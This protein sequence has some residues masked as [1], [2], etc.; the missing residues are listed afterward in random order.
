MTE[1]R[2]PPHQTGEPARARRSDE[3][4][5]RR[6]EQRTGK[7]IDELIV[8][9]GIGPIK[10]GPLELEQ[11]LIE[12]CTIKPDVMDDTE[13]PV[14]DEVLV[15]HPYRPDAYV[16]EAHV[17]PEKKIAADKEAGE[18]A[19]RDHILGGLTAGLGGL[20]A[21]RAPS[22]PRRSTPR[23]SRPG[24][25]TGVKP[26]AIGGAAAA[27]DHT[28]V[29]PQ[30]PATRSA[31]PPMKQT[32]AQPH[33]GR[34]DD[35]P[36]I[37]GK[38]ANDVTRPSNVVPIRPPAQPETPAPHGEIT[39]DMTGSTGNRWGRGQP[40]RNAGGGGHQ[41]RT[42][43]SR[44]ITSQPSVPPGRTQPEPANRLTPSRSTTRSRSPGQP[45]SRVRPTAPTTKN[46]PHSSDST[47]KWPPDA[48]R[49][50]K[51]A[52]GEP[53]AAEWRY[54]R[55]RQT[56]A[57]RGKSPQECLPFGE[58]KPLYFDTAAAGGRP[59]RRGGAEQVAAKRQLT[60]TEGVRETEDVRLG[61][62]Y[63]DGVASQPNPAG[64]RDYFEV[65]K[66]L[67]NGIP[68]ARERVKLQEEIDALA[69][70]DTITFVDKTNTANRITYRSGD[71]VE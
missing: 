10:I 66:M 25:S 33:R 50:P 29:K 19:V 42:P 60:S 18:A 24:G 1:C 5:A 28:P 44:K 41:G 49:G 7:R 21:N 8:G 22:P 27:N 9:L 43:A 61:N 45:V 31:P 52:F 63:P 20:A 4:I 16:R 54:A 30:A 23:A 26:P 70:N 56:C 3:E 58:W 34:V 46:A 47:T 15:P 59:G 51:P 11:R 35:H 57:A 13:H 36:L 17:G 39:L 48:P 68:E 69:P 6:L 12:N 55:Y 67:E 37:A 38:P 64:G 14:I 65:G 53:G 2:P 40:A 32:P 71:S 62:R